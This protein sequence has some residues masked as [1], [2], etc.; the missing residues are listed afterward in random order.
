MR[1]YGF[2]RAVL[3]A[4]SARLLAAVVVCAA[5]C[6]S[7][8]CLV[9]SL[10]PLYDDVSI[11]WDETLLGEWEAPEDNVRVLVSRAEW[12]SYRVRYEHPVESAE[13]TAHLTVIDDQYFIDLMPIRGQDFGAVLIPAHFIVRL[14]RAGER[15]LASPLDYDRFH[16]EVSRAGHA[17][18][19]PAAIDQKHN[20]ILTG[21]TEEL[22]VWLRSKGETVF[23]AGV[24]LVKKK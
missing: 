4:G 18:G 10:H 12:R 17:G 1:A 20:V 5:A 7:S 14:R 22:R 8:G 3:E 2:R 24:E 6:A 13:F 11:A 19:A 23:D 16:A 9:L 15:W 21:T